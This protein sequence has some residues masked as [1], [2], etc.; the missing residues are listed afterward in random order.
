MRSTTHSLTPEW[1]LWESFVNTRPG[2]LATCDPSLIRGSTK[3]GK[4]A[5]LLRWRHVIWR[6]KW[7]LDVHYSHLN[8]YEEDCLKFSW[9]FY[10]RTPSWYQHISVFAL[11]FCHTQVTYNWLHG[12]YVITT[13]CWRPIQSG[14]HCTQTR[15]IQVNR[16]MPQLGAMHPVVWLVGIFRVKTSNNEATY[17]LRQSHLK[18]NSPWIIFQWSSKAWHMLELSI[19]AL[20]HTYI[21]L[22]RTNEVMCIL[23]L[24]DHWGS[25]QSL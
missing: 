1:I 20:L 3:F 13:T 16:S 2:C 9:T 21:G 15:P 14:Q 6:P 5:S 7:W 18:S 11:G 8:T 12:I 23:H 25:W 4:P 24:R 19:K 22:A 10:L 17:H